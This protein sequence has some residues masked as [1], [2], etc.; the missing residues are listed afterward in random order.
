[1]PVRASEA[2][3][4]RNQEGEDEEEDD[5]GAEGANHVK[6][7]KDAHPKLEEAC[8]KGTM[9]VLLLSRKEEYEWT[10]SL[11]KLALNSGLFVPSVK[12][13]AALY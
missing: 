1:V 6:E 4:G 10:M 12:A 8:R 13:P 2:A 11:P 3:E 9:S 5:V 7:D